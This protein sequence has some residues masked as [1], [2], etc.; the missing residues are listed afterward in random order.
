[1]TPPHETTTRTQ[2]LLPDFALSIGFLLNKAAQLLL[3][4]FEK[5]LT[6]YQLSAREFDVLRYLDVNGGQ[7][8][9]Q[10]GGSLRI[11][12]ST[13]VAVID[14]LEHA[15]YVQRTRDPQDRRRYAVALTEDG[16]ERVRSRLAAVEKEITDQYLDGVSDKDRRTL[17][18]T[19]LTLIANAE[20]RGQGPD[21]GHHTGHGGTSAAN[22]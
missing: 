19:L 13:M 7:S 11:D 3:D 10:I 20:Q 4:D 1:M 21:Q 9:Q 14:N 5:A 2:N 8:Q 18:D 15:G 17:V 12:R 6:P 22:R 16:Q